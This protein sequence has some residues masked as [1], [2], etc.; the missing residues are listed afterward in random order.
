V[1]EQGLQLLQRS[2]LFD[3][4]ITDAPVKALVHNATA[5]TSLR[6]FEKE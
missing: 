4:P 6:Y 5:Q 1:D 3:I 2:F